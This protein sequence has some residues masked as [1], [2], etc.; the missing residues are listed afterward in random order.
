MGLQAV[1]K[2]ENENEV[3]NLVEDFAGVLKLYDDGSI[4]RTDHHLI[5]NVPPSEKPV[6]E[7]GG[8]ASRDVVINEELGIWVR[9]YLPIATVSKLPLLLYFH[10]GGFCFLSPAFIASHHFCLKLAATIGAIVVSVNYRLA[11]EFCLPAAYDDCMEVLQWLRSSLSQ[12]DPWLNAYADFRNVFLVGESS[13]GNIVHHLL[14]RTASAI[15]DK[16]SSEDSD[17]DSWDDEDEF[18]I[19]GAILLQPFFGAQERTQSEILCPAGAEVN[20]QLC[21]TLWRLSLPIG[22]SRDH[23]FSNPVKYLQLELPLPPMLVVLGGKDCL[24]DRGVEYYEA[25]H[26][27]SKC[28]RIDLMLF[29]GEEHGFYHAY[30]VKEEENEEAHNVNTTRLMRQA[31]LFV[32][33]NRAK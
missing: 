14:M 3:Q 21:D 31:A 28:K 18:G 25:I 15:H 13:G 22:S 6:A 1:A 12:S 9:I 32:S 29:D 30:S 27:S 5:M 24:C 2:K 19:R 8:V 4:V 10:G 16:G 17:S 33:S 26:N 20:V 23:P 11:P 7:D